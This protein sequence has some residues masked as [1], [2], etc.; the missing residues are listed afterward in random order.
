MTDPVGSEPL[1]L[2]LGRRRFMAVI[3][4]SLLAAPLAVEAQQAG[5]THHIGF[6]PSGASEA[7]RS[8][9]EALREGLRALGYVP[10][11]R[12]II[13]AVWP[14]T[15]SDLPESAASLVKQNPE[16]IVAP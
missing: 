4:G 16:V 10:D 8:Q 13:T 6:L 2:P 11:K 12:I 5:K 14:E 15:P 9:L 7:H 1:R 3:A